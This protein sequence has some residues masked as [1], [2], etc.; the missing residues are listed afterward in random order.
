MD[1]IDNIHRG[2]DRFS[3]LL[4]SNSEK[5]TKTVINSILLMSVL[6]IFGCFDFLTLSFNFEVF[7]FVNHYELAT[8][9]WTRVIAK[10]IA[11][12]ISYNVGMNLNWDRELAKS[13]ILKNLISEYDRLM[14]LKDQKTFNHFVVEIFNKTAKRL[15]W[16]DF[17]NIKIHKLN[18]RAKH[19]DLVLYSNGSDEAKKNNKYCSKRAELECLKSDEYIKKNI[20]SIIVNY[21]SVDPIVFD[22]DIDGKAT[23]RGAR[24]EGNV[25]IARTRKSA[26]VIAGIALVSILTASIILGGSMEE[27][28]NEMQRFWFYFL[29]VVEDVGL[30]CWQVFRGML[31][32]RKVINSEYTEPYANRVRVLTEY[33]N[34]CADDKIEDTKAYRIL[35]ELDKTQQSE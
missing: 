1:I 9:Y 6:A 27:F 16:V 22:L 28:E 23:S 19:S 10:T 8:S 26:S 21:Y 5:I 13:T 34:W 18:K 20:N 15:A 17:I 30:V 31:D 32:D 29:S 14:L 3:S 24:V 11:G 4:S 35:K 33:V 12:V 7:D 2:N 25:A